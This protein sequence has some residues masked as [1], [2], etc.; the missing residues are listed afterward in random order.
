MAVTHGLWHQVPR[1]QAG[2]LLGPRR[3]AAHVRLG[4]EPGQ[5]PLVPACRMPLAIAQPRRGQR[6]GRRT[7][8]E[9]TISAPTNAQPQVSIVA[10]G[11]GSRPGGGL[12]ARRQHRPDVHAAWR[13]RRPEASLSLPLELSPAAVSRPVALGDITPRYPLLR[14]NGTHAATARRRSGISAGA[15]RKTFFPLHSNVLH[16]LYS[17]GILRRVQSRPQATQGSLARKK[18]EDIAPIG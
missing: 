15:F 4:V 9:G 3:G 2:G 17:S 1:A 10:A 11:A 7:P 8:G 14:R 16:F 5:S 18:L 12:R 6:S 13:P